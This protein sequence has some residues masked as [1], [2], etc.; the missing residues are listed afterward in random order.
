MKFQISR[1]AC[2]NIILDRGQIAVY[3]A[4]FVYAHLYCKFDTAGIITTALTTMLG[5]ARVLTVL[6]REHLLPPWLAKIHPTRFTPVNATLVTGLVSG[7]SL[8]VFSAWLLGQPDACGHS[9]CARE[10]F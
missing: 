1:L 7:Q 5:Q 8:P 6:G 2:Y 4:V 3:R 10:L 9:L